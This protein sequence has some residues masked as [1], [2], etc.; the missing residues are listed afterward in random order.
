[1]AFRSGIDRGL[2]ELVFPGRRGILERK[3]SK[4]QRVQRETPARPGPQVRLAPRYVLT[5]ILIRKVVGCFA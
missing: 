5:L 1:M 2:L 4:V 3:V